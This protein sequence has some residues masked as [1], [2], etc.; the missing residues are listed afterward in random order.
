M[1][2]HPSKPAN[3]GAPP[4]SGDV[5]LEELENQVDTFVEQ[6]RDGVEYPEASDVNGAVARGGN[7]HAIGNGA[8]AEQWLSEAKKTGIFV[9]L[10]A[11]WDPQRI[12]RSF[13]DAGDR[14]Q[15]QRFVDQLVRVLGEL[16]AVFASFAEYATDAQ[17]LALRSTVFTPALLNADQ[18][19]GSEEVPE[20]MRGGWLAYL[21]TSMENDAHDFLYDIVLDIAD[22]D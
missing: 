17:M 21:M 2:V 3:E 5:S 12:V 16:N 13:E 9:G 14:Q 22:D 1:Y 4:P 18:A 7:R 10:P 11:G 6:Y 15:A 8:N 19:E 20:G